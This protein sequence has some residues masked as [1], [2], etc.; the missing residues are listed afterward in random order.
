MT[1][2]KMVKSTGGATLEVKRENEDFLMYEVE[3]PISHL[4]GDVKPQAI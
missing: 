4:S 2:T 3:T 1:F